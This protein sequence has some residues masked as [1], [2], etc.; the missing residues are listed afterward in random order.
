[1]TRGWSEKA[2]TIAIEFAVQ[3]VGAVPVTRPRGAIRATLH[4]AL[5]RLESGLAMAKI[6]SPVPRTGS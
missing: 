6:A 5:L 3:A 4:R 1:M 2:G